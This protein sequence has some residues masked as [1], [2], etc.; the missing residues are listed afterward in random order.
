MCARTP[1]GSVLVRACFATLR[2][3]RD[4]VAAPPPR[5]RRSRRRAY[6]PLMCCLPR[7]RACSRRNAAFGLLTPRSD[8]AGLGQRVPQPYPDWAGLPEGLLLQMFEIMTLIQG[9]RELVRAGPRRRCEQARLRH[10]VLFAA[11]GQRRAASA[12]PPPLCRAPRVRTLL[13]VP[14]ARRP[15]AR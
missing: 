11:H 12:A 2:T 9:G 5:R 10:T 3:R 1:G 6:E 13:R 4:P 7:R 14:A 8:N 15:R